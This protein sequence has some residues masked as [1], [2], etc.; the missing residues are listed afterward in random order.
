MSGVSQAE[1]RRFEPVHPR[2][3]KPYRSACLP[4][5]PVAARTVLAARL[6]VTYRSVTG[7]HG[8]RARENKFARAL[9][10]AKCWNAIRHPVNFKTGCARA[11]CLGPRH[12]RTTAGPRPGS[13]RSHG[14]RLTPTVKRRMP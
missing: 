3:S 6:A 2:S 7:D 10:Q 1:C 11:N 9:N 12:E 4:E 5:T 8:R 13:P 14:P